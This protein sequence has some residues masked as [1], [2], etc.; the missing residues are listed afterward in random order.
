MNRG[1]R[2]K[3]NDLSNSLNSVPWLI[4]QDIFYDLKFLA[5]YVVIPFGNQTETNSTLVGT[6]QASDINATTTDPLNS[7]FDQL[8]AD[9][10]TLL[11]NDNILV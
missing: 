3:F 6:T 7:L 5:K 11:I 8:Q 4:V 10:G 2:S 1:F 9:E